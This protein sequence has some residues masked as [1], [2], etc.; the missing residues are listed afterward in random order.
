MIRF[1]RITIKKVEMN[2]EQNTKHA[3]RATQV[4]RQVEKKT[5]TH[6]TDSQKQARRQGRCVGE[7]KARTILQAKH[8]R[9]GTCDLG[10]MGSVGEGKQGKRH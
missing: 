1:M 2:I 5:Y 4:E 8:M 9:R 3:A 6:D 7:T 10:S